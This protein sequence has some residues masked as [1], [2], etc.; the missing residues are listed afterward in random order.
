MWI[1]ATVGG[2]P[3]VRQEAVQVSDK[4]GFAPIPTRQLQR[5][6]TWLWSWNLG[7]PASTKQEDAAKDFVTWAT[8]KDYIELVAKENG[9]VV[10]AARHAPVHL[11]QRRLP[12]GGALRRRSC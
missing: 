3:A 8:S 2:R 6:P 10:G 4:V 11:R 12:E 5:R 7:I 9:W 1:D